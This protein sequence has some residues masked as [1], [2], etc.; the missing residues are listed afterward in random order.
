MTLYKVIEGDSVFWEYLLSNSVFIL[1][2]FFLPLLK[3]LLF[4]SELLC[5]HT[6]WAITEIGQDIETPWK[7]KSQ[8]PQQFEKQRKKTGWQESLK[9]TDV[10][11]EQLHCTLKIHL[12]KKESDQMVPK[13]PVHQIMHLKITLNHIKKKKKNISFHAIDLESAIR[14]LR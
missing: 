10:F 13:F 14:H 6:Y 11:D 2:S 5:F 9:I 4:F 1:C 12:K 3:T 8:F 7:K